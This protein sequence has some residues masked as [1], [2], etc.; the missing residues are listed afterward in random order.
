LLLTLLRLPAPD[1]GEMAQD[2]PWPDWSLLTV[3]PIGRALPAWTEAVPG[4][5]ETVIAAN[6]MVA[7]F[8]LEVSATEVALTVM[9]M[10]LGGGVLGGV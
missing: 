10:S 2:T 3:T 9:V 1:A 5:T 4:D 7:E 8:D 6:I